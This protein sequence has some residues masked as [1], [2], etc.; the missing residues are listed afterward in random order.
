[1]SRTRSAKSLQVVEEPESEFYKDEGGRRRC[2]TAVVQLPAGF[3]RLEEDLPLNVEL[4]FE[5]GQKCDD[6]E[7]LSLMCGPYDQYKIA[8]GE[9]KSTVDFRLEKVSRRKDG[10]RFKL[11]IEPSAP[12]RSRQALD[13]VFTRPITVMSKRRTGER[14]VSRPA[15]AASGSHHGDPFD[16]DGAFAL[17]SSSAARTSPAQ[18]RAAVPSLSSS[19]PT[20]LRTDMTMQSGTSASTGSTGR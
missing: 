19:L 8:A 5:S 2:M 20:H 10:Q 16:A 3:P 6:D 17:P 13:G 9:R 11:W 14:V 4:Y 7:I 1:M 15:P 18:P 12:S